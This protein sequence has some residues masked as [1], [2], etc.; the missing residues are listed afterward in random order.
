MALPVFPILWA[1]LKLE[2]PFAVEYFTIGVPLVSNAQVVTVI[3]YIGGLSAASG[4]FM[5]SILAVSTMV[6][7]HW[8][9]PQLNLKNR[10]NFY[11]QLRWLYRLIIIIVSIIAEPSCRIAFFFL[12]QKNETLTNTNTDRCNNKNKNN[13]DNKGKEETDTDTTLH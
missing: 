9:L 5:V 6:L 8:L 2:A 3:A 10:E 12:F 11:S 13:N 1:G 4:A 7:N